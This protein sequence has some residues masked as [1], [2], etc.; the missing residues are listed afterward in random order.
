MKK[1]KGFTY[2]ELMTGISILLLSFSFFI[3][4]I[5][6]FNISKV[7]VKSSNQMATIAQNAATVF[8]EINDAGTTKTTIESE[9]PDY[10]VS[11][12]E[13]AISVNVSKRTIDVNL[14]DNSMSIPN[15]TLVYYVP[16]KTIMQ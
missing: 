15:Y 8:G 7:T 4:M 16:N 10:L 12:T 2:I 14:K 13:R 11:V 6:Y 5:K 9:Y 1:I 3:V